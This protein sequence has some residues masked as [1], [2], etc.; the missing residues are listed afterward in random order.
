MT[1][2]CTSSGP[3]AIRS[4]LPLRHMD[5]IGPFALEDLRDDPPR[6]I[7]P[8]IDHDV[9]VK[10]GIIE[11]QQCRHVLFSLFPGWGRNA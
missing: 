6:G 3:S 1:I 8:I 9:Y 10:V 7:V 2:L 4:A 5:A 11:S